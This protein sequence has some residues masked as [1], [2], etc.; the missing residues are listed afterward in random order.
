M[1]CLNCRGFLIAVVAIL[2][3]YST[4]SADLIDLNDGTNTFQWDPNDDTTQMSAS[5]DTNYSFAFTP[6]LRYRRPN[7]GGPGS[8]QMT[9]R[10]MA[11]FANQDIVSNSVVNS[12]ASGTQHVDFSFQPGLGTPVDLFDVDLSFAL[13]TTPLGDSTLNYSITV[14]NTSGTTRSEVE[15]FMYFDWDLVTNQNTVIEHQLD[16]FTGFLQQADPNQG[17]PN[18]LNA[19]HGTDNLQDWEISPWSGTNSIED[20]LLNGDSLSNSGAPFAIGDATGAFGWNIGTM[21]AGQ[22][23]TVNMYVTSVP[24]PGSAT[25]VVLGLVGVALLRRRS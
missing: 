9:T 22:V 21:S 4:A 20:R 14:T 25:I 2:G 8:G 5:F 23:F 3:M 19:F 13:S 24:E 12:G 1:K 16:G 11:D 6:L 7:A 18:F 10:T 17:D 15:L